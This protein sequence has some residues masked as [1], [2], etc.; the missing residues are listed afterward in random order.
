MKVSG[1]K[2][3][4]NA[5]PLALGAAV[6]LAVAYFVLR[7]TVGDIAK[8]AGG[9]LTGDNAL[10]KGTAYEGAGI[11]GTLGAGANA[12]S[13][14]LLAQVGSWIGDKAFNAFNPSKD[15]DMLT[16]LLIFPDGAKHAVN[17]SDVDDAG[18][19]RYKDGKRYR[20]VVN[21]ANQNVAI[22]A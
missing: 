21:Q 16:Y 13:G 15:R 11:A 3:I 12:I 22:A 17:G 10:T 9:L 7:K 14:G 18:Y 20:V 19:F 4:D 5:L 6:V 8:G 2:L 1:D